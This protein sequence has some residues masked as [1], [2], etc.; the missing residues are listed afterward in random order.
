MKHYLYHNYDDFRGR[1]PRLLVSTMSMTK[2]N[3][4]LQILTGHATSPPSSII[5]IPSYSSII[6]TSG[7]SNTARATA[8]ATTMVPHK[9]TKRLHHKSEKE[10]NIVP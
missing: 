7:T 10:L 2:H 5:A 8:P 9:I 3:Y 6:T 1:L 4:H